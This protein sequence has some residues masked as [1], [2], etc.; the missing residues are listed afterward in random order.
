MP[1]FTRIIISLMIFLSQQKRGG[2]QTFINGYWRTYKENE[3]I[4][5]KD[6]IVL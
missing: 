5:E 2:K 6:V 4:G 3:G 1:Y